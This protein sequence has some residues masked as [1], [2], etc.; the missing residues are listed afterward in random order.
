MNRVLAGFAWVVAAVALLLVSALL[1]LGHPVAHRMIGRA[2]ER[3][4]AA[5][6]SGVLRIGEIRE[7]SF[8]RLELADVGYWDLAEK[9]K[10]LELERAELELDPRSLLEDEIHVSHVGIHGARM[11]FRKSWKRPE[12]GFMRK[13]D[14]PPELRRR[15]KRIRVDEIVFEDV[16]AHAILDATPYALRDLSGT[17]SLFVDERTTF[18]LASAGGTI[19]LP[20]E[21]GTAALRDVSAELPFAPD[22]GGLAQASGVVRWAGDPMDVELTYHDRD[23]PPPLAITLE[24]ESFSHG[25]LRELGLGDV[26]SDV[27]EPLSGAVR[28]D[29]TFRTVTL[30]PELRGAGG[31]EVALDDP[32][33][34]EADWKLDEGSE[35]PPEADGGLAGPVLAYLFLTILLAAVA[36]VQLALMVWLLRRGEGR[37]WWRMAPVA[38]S[39]AAWMRGARAA[40]ATWWVLLAI[41]LALILGSL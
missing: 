2:V 41:Y 25:Q 27:E 16:A 37:P 29:G 3:A 6:S 22:S 39:V 26:G 5:G 28:V 10:A 36:I 18:S 40:A 13:F 17:G 30:R 32:P 34:L 31:T 9:R 24:S 38:T 23:E 35:T 4:V 21:A 11:V 15:G 33:T 12:R 14:A 20:G 8:D 19:E 1:H 7:A